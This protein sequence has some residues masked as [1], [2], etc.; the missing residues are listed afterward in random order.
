MTRSRAEFSKSLEAPYAYKATK[1][2]CI[3]KTPFSLPAL[4][5]R[6]PRNVS[7][8][9]LSRHR[10]H[11]TGLSPQISPAK[12]RRN[13][14]PRG[15]DQCVGRSY[16][17]SPPYHLDGASLKMKIPYYYPYEIAQNPGT[18]AYD[19]T[20][21]LGDGRVWQHRFTPR[22]IRQDSGAL[23]RQDTPQPRPRSPFAGPPRHDAYPP[24]YDRDH[25]HR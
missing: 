11:F 19:M 3:I 9:M 22:Q 4:H 15:R 7:R 6:H 21:R 5:D 2:L 20:Y 13:R 17:Y 12:R 18:S 8:S 24:P 16:Y 23:S 10:V 14:Q 25:S 1:P